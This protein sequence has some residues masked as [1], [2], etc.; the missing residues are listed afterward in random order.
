MCP[1][2]WAIGCAARGLSVPKPRIWAH[3]HT[4]EPHV[5]H[6]HGR[7]GLSVHYGDTG[8][9][10]MPPQQGMCMS[11]MENNSEVIKRK[12]CFILKY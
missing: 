8:Q 11:L 12:R 10:G 3:E 7:K 5:S 2:V 4:Q 1:Q 6:H 9:A